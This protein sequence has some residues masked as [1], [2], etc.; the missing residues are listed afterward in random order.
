LHPRPAMASPHVPQ[1]PRL[2]ASAGGPRARPP[3]PRGPWTAPPLPAPERPT[4][5]SVTSR[6]RAPDGQRRRR[7]DPI[8]LLKDSV[9]FL[10]DPIAFN[11]VCRDSITFQFFMQGVLCKFWTHRH[12]QLT[13]P[14]KQHLGLARL[15]TPDLQNTL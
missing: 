2:T 7:R 10:K 11:F 8:A 4:P 9:A 14:T 15:N 5:S 6:A 3:A 12:S 1:S 13:Q